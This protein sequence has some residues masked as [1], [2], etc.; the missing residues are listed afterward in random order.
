MEVK[1]KPLRIISEEITAC[2]VR[3]MA[4][5][6]DISSSLMPSKATLY[7]E[8][9][10]INRAELEIIAF[11]YDIKVGKVLLS[12]LLHEPDGVHWSL[13]EE[14]DIKQQALELLHNATLKDI[15]IIKN[16]C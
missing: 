4:G 12:F 8:A 9:G 7:M 13:D 16:K 11:L 15:K 3:F 2:G 1:E 6:T 10:Q 5:D 14:K